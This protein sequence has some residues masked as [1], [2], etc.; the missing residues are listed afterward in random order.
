MR[1]R[2]A[3]RWAVGL[4]ACCGLMLAAVGAEPDANELMRRNFYATKISGFTGDVTMTLIDPHGEQRVRRMSIRSAL[5][6][7]GVD[8]AVMTRFVQPADIKGTGFLQSENSAGDDDIWVYLPALGKTR[9]LASNNKRDSFFGTDFAYGDILLPPVEKYQH[10]LLRTEKVEGADCYVIESK[11]VDEKTRNDSGY[12]RKLTW[13]DAGSF[14]ERKVEYYDIRDVL[15]KTQ[16]I[17]QGREVEPDKQRWLAL[18][19]QMTNHQTGHQTLYRIDQYQFDKNVG[20]HG[21]SV[22]D[23]EER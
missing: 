19:R 3:Y 10:T 8:S 7:N 18:E 14:L 5:K 15:L 4:L 1:P 23:L 11:P 13:V 20:E 17:S 9:R 22:R 21:F 2:R 6:S 12:G 16:V